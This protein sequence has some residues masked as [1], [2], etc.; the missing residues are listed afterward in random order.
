MIRRVLAIVIVVGVAFLSACN[1]GN[2]STPTNTLIGTWSLSDMEADVEATTAAGPISLTASTA[3]DLI[4]ADYQIVVT[5]NTMTASGSYSL[6]L[7]INIDGLPP[8]TTTY[9]FNDIAGSVDYSV[10]GN[11]LN[12]E[13]SYFDLGVDGANFS[14]AGTTLE[15]T[16]AIN[17]DQLTLT[18]NQTTTIEEDQ[19]SVN[20]TVSQ[21]STWTRQ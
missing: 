18:Q 12:V 20:V 13:G 8:T 5:E 19:A 2:D 16:Y 10:S 17:G 1:E 14:E 3:I 15:I 7:T 11:T 21:V 9:E 6:E 4:E